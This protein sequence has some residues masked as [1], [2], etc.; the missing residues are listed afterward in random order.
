MEME[1]FSNV[2][3]PPNNNELVSKGESTLLQD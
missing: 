3:V 2:E 1:S